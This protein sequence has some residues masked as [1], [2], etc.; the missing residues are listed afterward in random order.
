MTV[1]DWR[2][3]FKFS[4][5]DGKASISGYKGTEVDV[6]IPVYIGKNPVTEIADGAFFGC[7][8]MESLTI[9]EGVLCIGR[10]VFDRCCNLKD[11]HLPASVARI[12]SYI[13]SMR[14]NLTI[15]APAGSYAEQ[16]AKKNNIPFVAE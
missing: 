16:Y 8:I 13:G 15:H 14:S 3:I 12:D 4:I 7:E 6:Q 9:P 11:L 5:K 1:S 10:Q 2:K